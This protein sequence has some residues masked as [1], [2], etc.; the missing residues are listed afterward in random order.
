MKHITVLQSEAVDALNIGSVSVA[1]DVTFGGGGHTKTML[2]EMRDGARL[3]AVDADQTALDASGIEDARLTLVCANFRDIKAVMASVGETS[4]DAIIA[5][6][7]WRTDQFESGG[8]GFSFNG[9]DPLLMTFGDPEN[10]VFTA[11]D[12]VNEWSEESIA[13]IIYGYGEERAAR[14]IAH[15]IV[16]ARLEAPIETA[17]A[18]ASVVESAAG[19]FYRKS[20]LH[21]ATK[22]FQAIRI[23]V[24]DELGALKQLLNDGFEILSPGGRMAII[25]F[26]S[27]EDRI[28]K[29]TFREFAHDY[30][31]VR[32][33]KKPIIPSDEE[34]SSNPRARSAKL[35]VIEKNS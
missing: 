33:T 14:L 18:L 28:V 12:V 21:A 13:D 11:Y 31:A 30:D 19:K 3:I 15:A 17:Q 1:F 8:K 7:G 10:H 9:E 25:T 2:T 26:H 16:E 24:N 5:D 27:L 29:H 35:R 6:L 32:I 34:V 22:T 23:A 20:K 4:I